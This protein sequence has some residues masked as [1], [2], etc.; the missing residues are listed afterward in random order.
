MKK[1]L[2]LIISTLLFFNTA[3]SAQTRTVEK[4]NID[5]AWKVDGKFIKA[6][7]F[8]YIWVS[9]DRYETFFDEY[10]KKPEGSHWDEPKFLKFTDEVGMYLN[11]EVPLNHFV[12]TG[13]ESDPKIS[14]TKQ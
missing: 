11:K 13:W 9:G 4:S 7:C 5:E 3:Y 6:E 12:D 1:L 8:D 10:F 2:P 14:L